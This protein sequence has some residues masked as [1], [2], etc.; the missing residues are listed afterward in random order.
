MS[1]VAESVGVSFAPVKEIRSAT[2]RQDM[3]DGLEEF[4]EHLGGRLTI[5]MIRAPGVRQDIHEID[6]AV[7]KVDDLARR[8]ALGF[9]SRAPRWAIA[10]KF[11]PE[12]RHTL[13]EDIDVSVGRTGRVTPFAVLKPV[14]VGGV[15][16]GNGYHFEVHRH[17]HLTN[18]W[19]LASWA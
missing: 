4:R 17:L 2:G 7:V 13:L 14:F 10:Y 6:G 16:Q 1:A 19:G 8:E 11:P 12:E 18:Q 9:T 3:L 15:T 5:P